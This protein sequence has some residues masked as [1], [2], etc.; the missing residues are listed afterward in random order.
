MLYLVGQIVLCLMF[1]ALVGVAVGWLLRGLGTSRQTEV[2]E[3][4]WRTR[5]AQLE[6]DR[7]AALAAASAASAAPPPGGAED[8]A[9]PDDEAVAAAAV[10]QEEQLQALRERLAARERE[11]KSLR[12]ARA[13]R[14]PSQPVEDLV[15]RVRE[16]QQLCQQLQGH[17]GDQRA[18]NDQLIKQ[19]ELAQ[20]ERDTLIMRLR[21]T[22]SEIGQL[23]N[24]RHHAITTIANLQKEL[25]AVRGALASAATGPRTAPQETAAE[26]EPPAATPT[27]TTPPAPAAPAQPA[28]VAAQT[29]AAKPVVE[30]PAPP[31]PA[32][33][34]AT[35]QPAVPAAP[36]ATA[37][38][39]RAPAPPADTAQGRARITALRAQRTGEGAPTNGGQAGDGQRQLPIGTQP[40]PGTLPKPTP[41]YQPSWRLKQPRGKRDN[42]QSIYGIGPKLEARLNELGIFHFAQIASFGRDDI[43]WVAERLEAFP[44]RIL[45]DRWVD[46]ARTLARRGDPTRS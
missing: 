28:P 4:R 26:P 24:D 21:D 10:A 1:T 5:V 23:T 22:E 37:G 9:G 2:V 6:Q 16:S 19:L 43:L 45:R 39:S 36:A 40:P 38:A 18:A 14:Q 44:G 35:G 13:V 33:A 12:T 17:L 7:A 31:K 20:T 11:L 46:Q 34:P 42:L 25:R 27:H 8:A 29:A 32:A 15:E 30:S 41:G 3:A